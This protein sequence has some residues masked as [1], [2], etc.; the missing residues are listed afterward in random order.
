MRPNSQ[1]TVDLVTF[2]W[3]ILN[4]KF[5]FCAVFGANQVH[6]TLEDGVFK[7]LPQV[8]IITDFSACLTQNK[9]VK[10]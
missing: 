1:E 4:G 5:I 8:I 2:T 7:R 3:E 9:E 10:K 6:N